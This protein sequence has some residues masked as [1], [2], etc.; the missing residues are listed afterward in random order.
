LLFQLAKQI[1]SCKRIKN[2]KHLTIIKT[3]ILYFKKAKNLK[4][5]K[6]N[7]SH[8]SLEG[9]KITNDKV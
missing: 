1:F 9:H 2:A 4:Y 7:N 6:K 5:I 3:F 8:K